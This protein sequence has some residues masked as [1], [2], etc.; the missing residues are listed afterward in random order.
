MKLKHLAAAAAVLVGSVAASSAATLTNGSFESPGTFSG[1]FQTLGTGSAGL[2]GWTVVDGNVD[3]INTLWEHSDGD[4]SLDM[5]GSTG[6]TI[7]TNISDLTVGQEYKISFDMAGNPDGGNVSKS[8]DVFIGMAGGGT[9]SFDTTGQ[10]RADMG[11]ETMSFTF[12]AGATS[13]TLSFISNESNA[14]GPA[15][16]NVQIMA[17][18]PLPAGGLLLLSGLG[19]IAVLRRKKA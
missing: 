11:W 3:L 18:V 7:S 5:S 2:T 9:F 16:D 13:G 10:S 4:Y 6:G 8:L 15:L 1:S 17:N 14:F 12:V 19:G